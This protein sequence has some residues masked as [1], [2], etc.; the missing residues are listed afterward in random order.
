MTTNY[1]VVVSST[2]KTVTLG[3]TDPDGNAIQLEL[4]M[5]MIKGQAKWAAK[6]L[7]SKGATVPIYGTKECRLWAASLRVEANRVTTRT[8]V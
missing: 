1:P 7:L 4:Q 6:H 2:E 3:F 8:A 5:S